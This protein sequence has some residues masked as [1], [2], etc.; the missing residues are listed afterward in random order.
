MDKKAILLQVVEALKDSN[1]K[2]IVETVDG[3][4]IPT[5]ERLDYDAKEKNA[6]KA[7]T[8]KVGENITLERIEGVSRFAV[9]VNGERVEFGA[10]DK[11]D[12]SYDVEDVRAIW[13]A[14][15]N[16]YIDEKG[17]HFYYLRNHA[18]TKELKDAIKN[19][20]ESE[21]KSDIDKYKQAIEKIKTMG[22]KPAKLEELLVAKQAEGIDM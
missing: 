7:R 10:V 18:K 15:R 20:K 16:K 13:S 21:E 9:K 5:N 2:V 1:N 6:N 22:V 17:D 12:D 8:I 3:N 4:N 11:T 19:L 14:A